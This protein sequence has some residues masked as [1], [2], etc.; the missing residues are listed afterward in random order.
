[1]VLEQNQK[2]FSAKGKTVCQALSVL[3]FL[4]QVLNSI[5]VVKATTDIM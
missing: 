5:T 4:S 2:I 1:M 3:E